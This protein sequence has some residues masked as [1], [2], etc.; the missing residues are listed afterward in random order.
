MLS[1]NTFKL[2]RSD[3]PPWWWVGGAFLCAVVV[4]SLV[5]TDSLD[6]MV[7][8]WRR[9]EYSHS[10]LIPLI[11]LLLIW[12]R[13]PQLVD[14]VIR[15]SWWGSA[16]VAAL[17]GLLLLGCLLYTSPSPRDLSTSRMPSSA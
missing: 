5:S 2:K 10:Y 15:P 4:A 8:H 12:Q 11:A 13:L 6:F 7:R 17:I 9:E 1:I 14:A 3:N 16:G